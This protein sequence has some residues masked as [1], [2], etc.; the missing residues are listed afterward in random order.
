MV[1][2][3]HGSLVALFDLAGLRSAIARR[4]ETPFVLFIHAR[5]TPQKKENVNVARSQSLPQEKRQ[6]L[7]AKENGG[8]DLYNQEDAHVVNKTLR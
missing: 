1:Q 5:N 8:G 6:Q 2:F 7:H 3:C 4:K